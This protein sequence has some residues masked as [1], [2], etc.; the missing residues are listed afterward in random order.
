[1]QQLEYSSRSIHFASTVQTISGISRTHHHP[2]TGSNTHNTRGER[3]EFPTGTS[4]YYRLD[5][6]IKGKMAMA[7]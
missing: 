1:M 6:T 2:D 5:Y 7:G 4:C 3:G